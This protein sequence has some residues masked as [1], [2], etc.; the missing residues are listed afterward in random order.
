MPRP[1]ATGMPRCRQTLEHLACR[2]ELELAGS[3]HEDLRPERGF[4]RKHVAAHRL[5]SDAQCARG[6]GEGPVAGGRLEDNKVVGR[7]DE[8]EK[9]LYAQ[10]LHIPRID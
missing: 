6:R 8:S 7:A 5:L 4:E 1:L 9:L 10:H 2:G 3:A